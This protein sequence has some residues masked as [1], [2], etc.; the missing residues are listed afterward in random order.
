M[1]FEFLK[2]NKKNMRLLFTKL[3]L[4]F[5]ETKTEFGIGKFFF[6]SL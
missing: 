5:I 6:N 1:H 2:H 4:E 3:K